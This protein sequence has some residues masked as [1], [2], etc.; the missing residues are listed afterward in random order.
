MTRAIPTGFLQFWFQPADSESRNMRDAL[1]G[2]TAFAGIFL[3]VTAFWIHQSWSDQPISLLQ[4]QIAAVLNPPGAAEFDLRKLFA[5]SQWVFS[6]QTLLL[7]AL[8]I[9]GLIAPLYQIITFARDRHSVCAQIIRPLASAY[10]R[11]LLLV[12]L[13]LL[14]YLGVTLF[15]MNSLAPAISDSVALSGGPRDASVFAILTCVDVL[16]SLGH[17]L[18]AAGPVA[19]LL[20]VLYLIRVQYSLLRATPTPA[21]QGTSAP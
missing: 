18:F 2:H 10:L 5:T 1:A 16:F 11:V 3:A 12:G 21:G 4:T 7:V 20:P 8:F 17:L 6:G 19:L 15:L 14:L 13:I 9:L